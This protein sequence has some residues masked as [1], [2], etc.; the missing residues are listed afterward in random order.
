MEYGQKNLQSVYGMAAFRVNIT[1]IYEPDL[2]YSLCS[3]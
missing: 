2:L 3:S 1:S